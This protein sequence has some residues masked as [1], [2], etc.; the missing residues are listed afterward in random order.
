[1]SSNFSIDQTLTNIVLHCD[2]RVGHLPLAAA[3]AQLIG[4]LDHLGDSWM[5]VSVKKGKRKRYLWPRSDGPLKWVRPTGW[6]PTCHHKCCRCGRSARQLFLTTSIVMVKRSNDYRA[7][8]DR[9]LRTW[10]I[11]SERS[12]RAVQSPSNTVNFRNWNKYWNS[13]WTSFGP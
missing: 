10:S 12:N 3:T 1:M 5:P 8:R 11:H 6:P 7:D 2:F 13:T 4:Q 9:W